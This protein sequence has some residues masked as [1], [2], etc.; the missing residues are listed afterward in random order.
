MRH[1]PH[2]RYQPSLYQQKKTKVWQDRFKEKQI[3]I[4]EKNIS[5]MVPKLFTMWSKNNNN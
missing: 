4:Y 2:D 1:L 5:I 3:N